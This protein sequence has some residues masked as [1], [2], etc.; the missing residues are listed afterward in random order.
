MPKKFFEKFNSQVKQRLQSEL[1]QQN[2]DAIRISREISEAAINFITTF[3]DQKAAK[4]ST[5]K[6]R[7]ANHDQT[8]AA[9]PVDTTGLCAGDVS[10][11]NQEPVNA[12]TA[13]APDDDNSLPA[14]KQ[15]VRTV[16]QRIT[17]VVQDEVDINE[18]VERLRTEMVALQALLTTL[19]ALRGA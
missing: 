18:M 4:K 9:P 12:Q 15:S 1:Q 13:P 16:A 2:A 3:N 6:A 19:T 10:G 7:Q 17:A 5:R 14:I 11:N 8:A